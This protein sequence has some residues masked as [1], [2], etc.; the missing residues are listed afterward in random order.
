VGTG[1]S[2]EVVLHPVGRDWRSGEFQPVVVEVKQ[3]GVAD[4]VAVGVARDE[5]LGLPGLEP[6]EVVDTEILEHRQRV[7][8]LDVEVFLV[9]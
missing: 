1:T 8:P 6:L 7:G 4:Q 2:G 3:D 5:L 9:V